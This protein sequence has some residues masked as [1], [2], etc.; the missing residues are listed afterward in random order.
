MYDHFLGQ[1]VD[2]ARRAFGGCEHHDVN[3]APVTGVG[4]VLDRADLALLIGFVE[5][6][7]ALDHQENANLRDALLTVCEDRVPHNSDTAAYVQHRCEG[8]GI[9]FTW[10]DQTPQMQAAFAELAQAVGENWD[11]II[12]RSDKDELLR[13]QRAAKSHLQA[14][15][16]FTGPQALRDDICQLIAQA[17]DMQAP[18]VIP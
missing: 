17:D 13:W 16:A 4:V 6:Q 9:E 10:S 7:Q 3:A 15:L 2:R 14:L 1:A 5:T 18:P 12:E 8:M 11:E